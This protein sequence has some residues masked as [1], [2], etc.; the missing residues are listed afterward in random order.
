MLLVSVLLALGGLGSLAWMAQRYGRLA[1]T[2]AAR[3]RP[4]APSRSDPAPEAL[5]QVDAFLEVRRL[6]GR[7]LAAPAGRPVDAESFR[8]T[9]ERALD[10]V[11]MTAAAYERMRERYRAWRAGASPLDDPTAR[12]IERRRRELGGADLG[13]YEPLDR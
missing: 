10:E 8:A 9:R 7:A 13:P 4:A 3:A 1:G 11:G 2:R 12:A 5:G 6:V